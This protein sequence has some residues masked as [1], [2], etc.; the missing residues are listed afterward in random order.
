MAVALPHVAL[1]RIGDSQ[2]WVGRIF[3]LLALGWFGSVFYVMRPDL[4]HVEPRPTPIVMLPDGPHKVYLPYEI[5]GA[6]AGWVED[7]DVKHEYTAWDF[8]RRPTI[9][10]L[11]IAVGP[12]AAALALAFGALGLAEWRLRRR[13]GYKSSY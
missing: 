1:P 11:I 13:Y 8:M 7:I 2:S 10:F 3:L 6:Q 4:P 12:I 5:F 9:R